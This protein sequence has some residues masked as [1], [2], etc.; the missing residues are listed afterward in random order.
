MRKLTI[1][2]AFL[3]LL[4]LPLSIQ[5]AEF[6][7]KVIEDESDLPEKFCS[8]WEKGDYLITDGEYLILITSSTVSISRPITTITSAPTIERAHPRFVLTSI[9]EGSTF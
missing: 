6:Q 2:P 1:I 4:L 8:L 7:V 5:T 3:V 9:R